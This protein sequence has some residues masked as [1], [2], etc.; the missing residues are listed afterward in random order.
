MYL[1][2]V[3]L[4]YWVIKATIERFLTTII[5]NFKIDQEA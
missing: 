5:L 3:K 1:K 2:V 4:N